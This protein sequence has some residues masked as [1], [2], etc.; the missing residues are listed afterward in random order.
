MANILTT[1]EEAYRVPVDFE[2]AISHDELFVLQCRPLG[3]S[4]LTARI[5]VPRDVPVEDRVFSA[6]R[7]VNNG[8]L[9]DIDYLVLVDPRDYGRLASVEE[10]LEVARVV[11]RINDAL[12]DK[13]FVLM[14]PGRWGTQ[15]I[16]LGIQIGFGDIC[17][18]RALIE[19]ARKAEGYTPE[20]SFGTHFFQ[21]LIEA[22]IL[23][24]PLYPDDEGVVFNEEF[25]LRTPNALERVCPD[26][27]RLGETI[28]VIDVKEVGRGRT[29]L[30]VMDGELQEGLCYMR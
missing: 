2:F 15:N 25:L 20:P 23:Y 9:E 19:I 18:A 17:N 6:R 26:D 1:L 10:R 21:E 4:I 30:L 5:P 8:F 3:S 14:G 16:Q 29:L 12:A 13:C 22:S 11:G 27:S 28:R 24:L 7:Y